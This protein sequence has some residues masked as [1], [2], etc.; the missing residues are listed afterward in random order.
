MDMSKQAIILTKDPLLGQYIRLSLIEHLTHIS[1]LACD[2]DLAPCAYTIV[3]LDTVP[4][5]DN[6]SGR[7]VVCSF[8]MEKPADCPYIWLDRPFR[9]ERLLAVLGLGVDADA[10]PIYPLEGRQAVM[11]DGK[12][13]ALTEREYALF[14]VLWEAEGYVSRDHLIERVWGEQDA[15]SKLNVYIH[16][17]RKKLTV[18]GRDYIDAA[19]GKGYRIRK[20]GVSC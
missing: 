16:Y 18:G 15:P 10:T 19:R 14:M 5:P 11:V 3:D 17:L 20:G 12:E 4:I 9:P 8:A 1:V 13:V 7:V 2:E 6:P